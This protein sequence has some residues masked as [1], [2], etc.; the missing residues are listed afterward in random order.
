MW[1]QQRKGDQADNGRCSDEQGI[2][3]LPPEQHDEA[4]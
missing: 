4:I 1:L 2:A 3:D